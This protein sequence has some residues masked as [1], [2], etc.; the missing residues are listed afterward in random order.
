MAKMRNDQGK[1]IRAM[2]QASSVGLVLVISIAIGYFFG[3]W[4][5]SK[6]GTGPWLMLAFTLMGVAAGFI[7]VIRIVSNISRD[8]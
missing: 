6:L 7:E 4:L 2:G 3:S 1:W 5:D 8:E